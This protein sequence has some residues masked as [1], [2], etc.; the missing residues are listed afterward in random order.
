[1]SPTLG[2]IERKESS[3][4][5]N[6]ALEEPESRQIANDRARIELPHGFDL[7]ATR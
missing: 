6:P 7:A 1:M 3:W 2:A 4:T 5:G